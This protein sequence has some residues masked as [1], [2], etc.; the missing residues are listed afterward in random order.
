MAS[1]KANRDFEESIFN[2]VLLL[3]KAI[4]WISANMTIDQVY[5]ENDIKS[6]LSDE[7]PEKYYSVEDLEAWAE[8][9]RFV[10]EAP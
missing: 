1:R 8:A 6:F 10:K 9:N 7:K 2:D 5:D 4:E 3:D